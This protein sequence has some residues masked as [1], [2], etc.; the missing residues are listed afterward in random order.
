M[1][2]AAFSCQS[3]CAR[4]AGTASSRATAILQRN[5]DGLFILDLSAE[6]TPRFDVA[7]AHELTGEAIFERFNF[8]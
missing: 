3:D 1:L 4:V 5:G 7:D 2:R 8:Y 6:F